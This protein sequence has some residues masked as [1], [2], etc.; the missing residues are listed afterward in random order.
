M[1]TQKLYPSVVEKSLFSWVFSGH[2]KLKIILLLT[3]LVTV[4]TRVFPLEMQK[5][6]VN[7]F[8]PLRK[9][10][11]IPGENSLIFTRLIRKPL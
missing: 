1:K 3:I 8:Y 4:F 5:R 6:I 11:S 2:L 7:H 10:F 9:K